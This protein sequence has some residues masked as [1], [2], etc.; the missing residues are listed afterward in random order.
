MKALLVAGL[1]V[2]GVLAMPILF[3]GLD[4]ASGGGLR[5]PDIPAVALQAY[6]DAAA[7]AST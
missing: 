1:P 3:I 5:H 4:D 6:V 7:A 2:L